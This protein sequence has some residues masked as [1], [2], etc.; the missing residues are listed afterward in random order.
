VLFNNESALLK[1]SFENEKASLQGELEAV[2]GLLEKE[3]QAHTKRLNAIDLQTKELKALYQAEVDKVRQEDNTKLAAARTAVQEEF[4]RKI[5]RSQDTWADEKTKLLYGFEEEKAKLLGELDAVKKLLANETTANPKR[6][7]M[8]SAQLK[9]QKAA[10]EREMAEVRLSAKAELEK[11]TAQI[12]IE[13]DE[14]TGSAEKRSSAKLAT[15]EE[16]AGRLQAQ[17]RAY[18]DQISLAKE[19]LERTAD[20][21]GKKIAAL[22]DKIRELGKEKEMIARMIDAEKEKATSLEN[23]LAKSR[24]DWKEEDKVRTREFQGKI[25]AEKKVAEIHYQKKSE[26]LSEKITEL[27]TEVERHQIHS[28]EVS[29][30]LVNA[31]DKINGLNRTIKTSKEEIESILLSNKQAQDT[32]DY[33]TAQLD[34][35]KAESAREVAKAQEMFDKNL[36]EK[37]QELSEKTRD[38]EK[39]LIGKYAKKSESLDN[40]VSSLQIKIDEL[41]AE[42]KVYLGQLQEDKETIETLNKQ[43]GEVWS[44][45][46]KLKESDLMNE[47]RIALQISEIEKLKD[48]VTQT[49][50]ENLEQVAV[51]VEAERK[52]LSEQFRAEKSSLSQE[53]AKTKALLRLSNDNLSDFAKKLSKYEHRTKVGVTG[54]IERPQAPAAEP[55][56][57]V[58]VPKG[59]NFSE[60]TFT[61]VGEIS[62]VLFMENIGRVYVALSPGSASAVKEGSRLYIVENGSPRADLFVV[63]TY[64][65]LNSAIAEF[66][67]ENKTL[68]S[69]KMPVSL[70]E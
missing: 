18:I 39:L 48:Q 23:K 60:G 54:K 44:Q 61:A 26:V 57:V 43:I 47:R 56:G 12:V 38:K 40:K 33:L 8:L 59:V 25:D 67:M 70:F 66:D 15:L 24:S 36:K 19:E 62:S 68:I 7:E 4:N 9:E 10:A 30:Q 41:N 34:E 52:R 51:Q 3:R 29:A 58:D 11:K 35:V 13:Y 63:A 31:K 55:H 21:S 20:E 5:L 65:A 27:Q 16:Q 2:K 1:G 50:G 45:N 53:L 69:E 32:I 37:D 6:V 28:D 14:K 49:K 22:E 17:N 42:R 46:A 64:P